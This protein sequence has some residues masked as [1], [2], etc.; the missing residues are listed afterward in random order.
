MNRH[1]AYTELLNRHRPMVWRMCWVSSRGDFE[2]CRDLVQEVSI[3]IWLHFDKLRPGASLR[4]E[5][6]WVRLLIRRTLDHQNRGQRPPMVA[7]TDAMAESIPNVDGSPSEEDIEELMATLN[8]EEQ[9]LMRLHIEGYRADEIADVMGLN[10]DAVYQR[11]HRALSKAR[12][13]LLAVLLVA[14]VSSIAVAVVPQWRE[15]VFPPADEG[16]NPAEEPLKAPEG[17]PSLPDTLEV[18]VDTPVH[19]PSWV[20]PPPLPHLAAVVDTSLPHPP[21][22]LSDPCKCPD[23]RRLALLTNPGDSLDDPCEPVEEEL[24]EVTIIVNGDMVVVEGTADEEVC[25]FDAQGRL[26]TSARCNGHCSLPIR[27]NSFVSNAS[28]ARMFWVQVGS[29]HRQQIFLGARNTPPL[30]SYFPPG[31]T[32]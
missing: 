7:M 30:R 5:K 12:R 22:T 24:P 29:R 4:E 16:E 8:P 28:E 3:V 32:F 11:M 27:V 6:A 20:P 9:Q 23:G 19:R 15:W 2:R 25:V 18:V 1:S 31:S 10:R 21:A 14:V 13:V 17:F 26:V